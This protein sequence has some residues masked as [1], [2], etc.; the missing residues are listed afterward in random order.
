MTTS[1]LP[2]DPAAPT[3]DVLRGIEVLGSR[4]ALNM[5]L[6]TALL[7]LT[8]DLPAIG[9]ELEAGDVSAAS[10]RMHGIK[11]YLP[12]FCSDQLVSEFF[13]LQQLSKTVSA[14]TMVVGFS[15]MQ[16]LLERL[17][18]EIQQYLESFPT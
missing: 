1:S 13:A 14:A 16:P 9:R 2:S 6:R 10:R 17:L 5:I 8:D 11:G 15:A 12:I 3:L 18:G 4:E 7:S